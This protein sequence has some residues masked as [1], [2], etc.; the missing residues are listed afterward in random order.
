VAEATCGGVRGEG[1]QDRGSHVRATIREG[2]IPCS[3]VSCTCTSWRGAAFSRRG[4][5][6]RSS[7]TKGRRPRVT[8]V[9]RAG[10]GARREADGAVAPAKEAHRRSA[11]RGALERATRGRAARSVHADRALGRG[12]PA[13]RRLW[14]A[15]WERRRRAA[16]AT[17]QG[18][19]DGGGPW[20]QREC[21]DH[22]ARRRC[23]GTRAA[24]PLRS[25]SRVRVGATVTPAGRPC[26]VSVA[27]AEAQRVDAPRDDAYLLLSPHCR[28]HSAAEISAD[29]AERRARAERAL[30]RCRRGVRPRRRY[31]GE[32]NP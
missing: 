16:C 4:R 14:R 26:G 19:V 6:V 31:G 21:R 20:L 24:L 18:A 15:A 23:R 32:G 30:A 7:F 3:G 29:E 13:A 10:C 9:T 27:K 22:G 28:A 12:V 8:R 1:R 25:A 2:S 11:R 17:R 5:T